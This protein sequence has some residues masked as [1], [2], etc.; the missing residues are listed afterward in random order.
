MFHNDKLI[1][2]IKIVN[3]EKVDI[4]YFDTFVYIMPWMIFDIKKVNYYKRNK[5][6]GFMS[7]KDLFSNIYYEW[8]IFWFCMFND[9]I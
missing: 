1:E 7:G 3:K 4:I 9:D 6:Y 8:T 5:S 2:L